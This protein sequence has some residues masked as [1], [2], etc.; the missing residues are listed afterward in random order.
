MRIHRTQLR[1]VCGVAVTAV[2]FCTASPGQA[3]WST[4]RNCSPTPIRVRVPESTTS[5]TV[6]GTLCRPRVWAA[7]ARQVDVLVHG[8]TYNRRYWDLLPG[9]SH[10]DATLTQGR[11][12]Y[13]FDQIGT[14][15][16]SRP[17]S[18]L[19][20][21]GTAG[22]ALHQVIRRL[23]TPL[24]QGGGGFARVNLVGHSL[25]A[26][27]AI[28]VAGRYRGDVNRLVV[29]GALHLP[30]TSGSAQQG[31]G[32]DA[33]PAAQDPL[34]SRQPRFAR[35][36]QGY[37]TTRP[38]ARG[39]V[40][41]HAPGADKSVVARDEATKDVV[42]ATHALTAFAETSAPPATNVAARVGP[43]VKV[44][45]VVGQRDKLMCTTPGLD[46]SSPRALQAH[47]RRYFRNAAGL[48]TV[49][50]PGT[51]HDL[52]LHRS[53]TASFAAINRWIKNS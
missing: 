2:L 33:V 39:R 8:G 49:V 46:C 48:T 21:V 51:G 52:A 38:G 12:V 45:V 1:R 31:L 9:Y 7:G 25:G 23:R 41:Y 17:P 20:T 50:V 47:E 34:L 27:T 3:G 53:R 16:S 15:T 14:G 40:F 24:S 28:H 37:L 22:S 4:T 42:S 36:D 35:L 11:A 10:V 29:T 5:Y 30:T 13:S 44:L 26:Y 43:G 32:S 19:V 6:Q 18:T